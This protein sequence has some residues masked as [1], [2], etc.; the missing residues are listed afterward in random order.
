MK[1]KPNLNNN[2]LTR[3]I[4]GLDEN[5]KKQKIDVIEE[6]PLT[7]YLNSQEIVTMMTINDY[8][9]YLALGYL[10]NQNMIT[11]RTR[12]ESIEYDKDLSVV[13]VR[14]FNQTNFESKLKKKRFKVAGINVSRGI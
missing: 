4:F 2:S 10:L 11:N 8:P 5:L 3:E 1:I 12:I 9:E 6:K 13:V 14:T 7:L